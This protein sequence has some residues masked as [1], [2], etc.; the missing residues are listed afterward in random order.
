MAKTSNKTEKNTGTVTVEQYRSDA[1]RTK[2]VKA[3]LAALGLG[4]IGKKK[5]LTSNP[6]VEGMI[7]RV[8]HLVRVI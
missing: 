2:E 4:R 1:G 5:T 3:T 8:S 7:K 6:A